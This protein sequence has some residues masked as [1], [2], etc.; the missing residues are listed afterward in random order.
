MTPS[1]FRADEEAWKTLM[2]SEDP[3]DF[4]FFLEEFPASPLAKTA[5]FKLRQLDRKQAKAEAEQQQL[6]EAKR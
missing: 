4:R 6:A 2:D 3:E 5:K 1:E